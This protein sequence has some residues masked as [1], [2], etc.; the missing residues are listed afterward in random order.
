MIDKTMLKHGCA[1][2]QAT[3]PLARFLT[4]ALLVIAA[5][6]PPPAA[7]GVIL[8]WFESRWETIEKKIPDAF[9]AGYTDYWFPPPYKAD[10]GGYSVGYD[11]FDRFNLGSPFDQ[12]LY[13]TETGL[14]RVVDVAHRAGQGVYLDYVA[15]HNGFR[16]VGT[17][18]F[19]TGG[20]YPG[21]AVTLPGDIDGDFHGR[22]EGGDWNGRLAGL[23][24]IAQEKN[25]RFVRN[26]TAA[27]QNAPPY[28]FP[29]PRNARFYP[30]PTLPA[31]AQ[32]I[33]PFNTTNPMAGVPYEENATGLL[34]RNAQYLIQ[35][36]GADGLR[37]DAVK[38][39]PDW[40]WRDF[41]DVV[42]K[43]CGRPNLAGYRVTPFS[44]GECYDGSFDTLRRYIRKDGFGNRDVKD[45]PLFFAMRD[46]L[47]GNGY[48]DMRRLEFASFDGVDGNANDGTYG[49]QFA[50]SHDN[51][52]AGL[53]NV[54]HAYILTRTGYPIVYFNAREFGTGRDFPQDGRGDALGGDYGTVITRLV[55]TNRRYAKGAFHTRWIDEDTFVYERDNSLL[56]GISDRMDSG[57]DTRT[58]DTAFRNITLTELTGVS[59][60]P[61][62]NA[63]GDFPKTLSIGS[64]GRAT[65]RVPRN[66]TNANTHG[67][68]TIAY[69]LEAPRQSLT[70]SPIAA[71]LAPDTTA[72]ANGVRR[73]TPL[74]VVT[75]STFTVSVQCDPAILDDN[76]LLRVNGGVD[77][78]AN[79][80]LYSTSGEFAGFEEFTGT[81]SPRNP[82]GT[83]T[84]SLDI[85]TSRLPEGPAFLETVAFHPRLAGEPTCWSS[86]RKVL[87]IDL[88]PPP[89]A[90][91]FPST[92]GVADIQSKN[93]EVVATC[94]DFTADAMHVFFD[95]APSYDFAGNAS[96][97]NRMTRV[98]RGEFRFTWNGIT[99][100]QHTISILAFEPTGH[101]NVVHFSPV[102]AAIAQPDLFLG[103]D[104]DPAPGAVDFQPL[105]ATIEER[106]YGR[107]FVVRVD[108]TGG[109][110][111]GT[112]FEVALEIDGAVTT[113]VAYNAGLLP[114]VNRLV[115]NDQN[116]GDQF[117]EFRMLWRGYAPGRHR[118]EARARLLTGSAP[119]NS[120]SAMVDVPST[121]AGPACAIVSPAPGTPLNKPTTLT[122]TIQTDSSAGSAAAYINL[123]DGQHL[124]GAVNAPPSPTISVSSSVGSV[125]LPLQNGT[126]LVRAVAS[127]GPNG[128]GIAADAWSSVTI[129]GLPGPA[130]PAPVIDG[131]LDWGAG[132]VPVAGNAAPGDKA[133]FGTAYDASQ[134]WFACDDTYLCFFIQG[135]VNTAENGGILFL[136]DTSGETGRAAGVSLGIGSGPAVFSTAG[137]TDWK[138]DFEVDHAWFGNPGYS[139]SAFYIDRADYPGT[140]SAA[141]FGSC[142]QAGTEAAISAQR[143][144]FR[145][146]G[147]SGGAGDSTGW[148]I[149]IPRSQ[150]GNLLRTGQFAAFAIVASQD[151]WFSNDSAPAN[152]PGTGHLGANPDFGAVPGAQ[153]TG[154]NT[155]PIAG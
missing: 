25:N 49:V 73:L 105:P 110:V 38:H 36:V 56:V 118:I 84:Y 53:N 131:M 66:R 72:T 89:V 16:D 119:A 9:M 29:D 57:F 145:N 35:S 14:R 125:G 15:N 90:L 92:T 75:A 83:G 39:V 128:S 151:A 78:D 153:N 31:N 99:N 11:V 132:Y 59:D 96:S 40:F 108:T 44:F 98:D 82:S 117:D 135:R 68:G 136:L 112:D 121:V 93:Y 64:D 106:A 126:Y 91:S 122:V 152:I 76:A 127:T 77:V 13:G 43:D 124:I 81:R 88:Q 86:A 23:I 12:T 2:R 147:Q 45:F 79:P 7:A 48:G 114:P 70:V 69:G 6:A 133:S 103:T 42:M 80:G 148:E 104:A 61:V 140:A 154:Y 85:E 46:V 142:D 1:R 18:G 149:A 71:V 51:G 113:A 109:R 102:G 120:V 97:A 134:I 5:S 22:Y 24:D 30:D 27:G 50:Q 28:Q 139:T 62:V 115:Q 55:D 111:F 129:T 32:G 8:Q 116:L 155:V 52:P 87:Y 138:A 74:N 19:A 107:E 20:G 67:R 65:I 41:F 26:P 33:R 123:A 95:R 3:R 144:A 60:D 21:F 100:G 10:T 101:S 94:P 137:R 150:L 17:P 63:N 143:H 4:L 34:V 146:L 37:L 47:T 130:L 141:Y 54:A 58:V